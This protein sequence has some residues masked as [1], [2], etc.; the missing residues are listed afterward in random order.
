MR[1]FSSLLSKIIRKSVSVA[2]AFLVL[3]GMLHAKY[4][5]S[6]SLYKWTTLE[7]CANGVDKV[8]FF[9]PSIAQRLN[10]RYCSLRQYEDYS[11]FNGYARNYL[12]RLESNNLV[13]YADW[14]NDDLLQS[15]LPGFVRVEDLRLFFYD[16]SMFAS[17]AILINASDKKLHVTQA[18]LKIEDTKVI[19]AHL[20]Q[21]SNRMEKNWVYIESG[22][23]NAK[24]L[25]SLVPLQIITLDLPIFGIKTIELNV[26]SP[27]LVIRNST[28]LIKREG[29]WLCLAHGLL[30]IWFKKIYV[31]YFVEI[32]GEEIKI[33]DPFVFQRF[34]DE[35]ALSINENNGALEVAFGNHQLG[36]FIGLQDQTRLGVSVE[37]QDQ[38]VEK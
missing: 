15:E 29:A 37:H 7:I 18:I 8:S 12:G 25:Y 28:N 3:G 26:L 9:N 24:F 13:E 21:T 31:H 33:S 20:F 5:K 22:N 16:D 27:S 4:I 23:G 6:S 1:V 34:S 2:K 10:R 14:L 32:L 17:A 30:D 36:A 38:T 19:G 11:T 35:F